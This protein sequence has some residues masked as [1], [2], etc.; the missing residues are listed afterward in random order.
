MSATPTTRSVVGGTGPTGQ[1]HSSHD[2][3]PQLRLHSVL[4]FGLAYLAPII[5]LGTFGVISDK[6]HGGTAGSYLISLVA[7][8]LTAASYGRLSRE[9]PMAGSAYTYVRRM[10]SNHLGFLV[11]WGSLL[12]YVF[13]PMVIWLIGASYLNAA[14]PAVPDWTWILIFIVSTTTLN[15]LGIKV[16]DKAN[17]V[18]LAIEILVIALFTV[19]AVYA[20]LHH[21][22]SLISLTPFTGTPFN[23]LALSAGAA[24][25]A[26]SFLGFDA[27]TTLTEETVDARRTIP[28]A[29]MLTALVGGGIFVVSTYF[30]ELVHPL[31][32]V[33]DIDSAAFEIAKS[34]GG[35]FLSAVFL[36]GLIVGQFASGIAAQA[37]ASRLM[38]AMGRDGVLP[39]RFFGVVSKRTG[40]PRNAI[41]VVAVVGLIGCLLDVSTS[42][43]FINFGAFI[44]FGMVNVAAIALSRKHASEAHGPGRLVGYVLPAL[45]VLV[46]FYLL[47]QLDTPALVVGGSWLVIGIG[48]LT[49][50]TRGFHRP[51]PEMGD[52]A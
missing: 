47:T 17:L 9:I 18:L 11:G 21:G 48:V 34:I 38:F 24:T 12:D 3:R 15:I 41:L 35:A 50:L 10:V 43:S 16:A 30:T 37:S 14:F 33:V 44:A 42:T 2:L 32:A 40:T 20:V 39:K 51:P 49:W 26:Y 7:M 23:V 8:L 45:G 1:A 13:I 28:K 36:T 5:V 4:A 31:V 22:R 27:V 46:V 52:A 29:I 6:S 19:F 25:A